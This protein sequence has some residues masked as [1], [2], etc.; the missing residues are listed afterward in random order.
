MEKRMVFI[1]VEKSVD[2]DLCEKIGGI[3]HGHP[4]L[5]IILS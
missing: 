5:K 2:L 4:V 3:P 1:V